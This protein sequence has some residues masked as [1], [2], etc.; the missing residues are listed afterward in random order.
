MFRPVVTVD[1]RVVGGWRLRDGR[2]ELDAFEALDTSDVQA[3]E[4][5]ADD[6]AAFG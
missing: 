4:A 1:G 3:L 5:E 2:A 6:V